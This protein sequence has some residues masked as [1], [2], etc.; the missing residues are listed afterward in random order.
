MEV[1]DALA[2]IVEWVVATWHNDKHQLYSP[3][4]VCYINTPNETNSE[5][6][7]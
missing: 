6:L 5:P 2:L 1:T 4:I 7:G 3:N